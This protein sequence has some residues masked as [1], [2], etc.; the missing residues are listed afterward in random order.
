MKKLSLWKPRDLKTYCLPLLF[1]LAMSMVAVPALSSPLIFIEV[2]DT[3]ANIDHARGGLEKVDAIYDGTT[4]TSLIVQPTS[5]GYTQLENAFLSYKE[6][7]G[8][9]LTRYY[10]D[11]KI[12]ENLYIKE[13]TPLKG[14]SASAHSFAYVITKLNKETCNM[15]NNTIDPS[16]TYKYINQG[17]KIN[18]SIEKAGKCEDKNDN[19]VVILK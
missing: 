17:D 6:Q 13:S 4:L 2:A 3:I 14:T 9:W 7:G 8:D 15:F 1:P 16:V 12:P 18:T 11:K 10:R 5:N 19:E